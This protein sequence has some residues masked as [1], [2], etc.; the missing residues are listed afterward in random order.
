M[1]VSSTRDVE[2]AS[3]WTT[4]YKLF[5][6][7]AKWIQCRPKTEQPACLDLNTLFILTSKTPHYTLLKILNE[8]YAWKILRVPYDNQSHHLHWWRTFTWK[9]KTHPGPPLYFQIQRYDR[10]SS[11]YWSRL[12]VDWAHLS[13]STMIVPEFLGTEREVLEN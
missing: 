5:K 8:T 2:I 12:K 7:N 13:S 6:N 9:D 1:K 3:H 4:A 10:S 11:T